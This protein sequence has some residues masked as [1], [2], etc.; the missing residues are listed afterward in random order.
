M[1]AFPIV[2][3]T[4]VFVMNVKVCIVGDTWYSVI[5]KAATCT[6]AMTSLFDT[7]YDFQSV[8]IVDKPGS[9]VQKN[10]LHSQY[11]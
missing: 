5:I 9:K 6:S 7:E 11:R 10:K 1:T 2:H 8:F 4:L 3:P